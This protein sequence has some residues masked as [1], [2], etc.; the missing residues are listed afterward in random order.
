MRFRGGAPPQ[1]CRQESGKATE[2][3]ARR[4]LEGPAR[5][6]RP[7]AAR[8]GGVALPRHGRAGAS[9][10]P[11]DGQDLSARP[12]AASPHG[13]PRA[14][15]PHGGGL[16]VSQLFACGVGPSHASP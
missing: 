6:C 1:P 13:A 7:P 4:G 10:P 3:R 15:V 12:G 2:S 8:L 5:G 14:R 11:S 9:Q 16:L